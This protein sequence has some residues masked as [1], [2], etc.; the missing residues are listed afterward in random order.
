MHFKDLKSVSI[1]KVR[2]D[3]LCQIRDRMNHILPLYLL[4]LV[5][6]L[7]TLLLS[8]ISTAKFLF[9]SIQGNI[10]LTWLEVP[11]MLHLKCCTNIMDL[12]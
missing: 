11:I 5:V 1:P 9:F 6:G 2:L 4:C 3:S 8:H 7:Y 12:K 10:F